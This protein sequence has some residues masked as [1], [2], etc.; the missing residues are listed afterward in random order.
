MSVKGTLM[1]TGIV[2]DDVDRA[3]IVAAALL[4]NSAK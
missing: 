3:A 2:S 1:I 4:A